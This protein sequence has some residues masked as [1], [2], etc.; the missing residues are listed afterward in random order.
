MP[1]LNASLHSYRFHTVFEARRYEGFTK[2]LLFH[3]VR[4]LF[5]ARRYENFTP[6]RLKLY[7]QRHAKMPEKPRKMRGRLEQDAATSCQPVHT[8]FEARRYEGFTKVLLFHTVCI[9]F[10]ARRYENFTP[11]S[12]KLC[13]LWHMRW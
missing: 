3:T 8:V 10:E 12:L 11:S 13:A 6:S 4:I 5:E 9:L 1:G 2:V 7:A